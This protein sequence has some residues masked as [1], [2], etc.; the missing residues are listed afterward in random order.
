MQVLTLFTSIL[1]L[2]MQRLRLP[3]HCTG[4]WAPALCVWL[5]PVRHKRCRNVVPPPSPICPA[6]L[7]L[8]L[9]FSPQR[10]FPKPFKPQRH[11]TCFIKKKK[12]KK[13]A[14]LTN[15]QERILSLWSRALDSFAVLLFVFVIL[16]RDMSNTVCEHITSLQE[17]HF[18][19]PFWLVRITLASLHRF[20]TT[21][22][23]G[24]EREF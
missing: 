9:P 19:Q 15:M 5:Q 22:A 6:P 13:K 12:E 23:L 18:A 10:F 3:Q 24:D 21:S 7:L 14:S 16:S 2:F 1:L 4:P 8:L 17:I 20:T 11:Q